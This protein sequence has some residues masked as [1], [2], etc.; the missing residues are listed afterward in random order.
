MA[1]ALPSAHKNTKPPSRHYLTALARKLRLKNHRNTS[2]HHNRAKDRLVLCGI[3]RTG[4]GQWFKLVEQ[5]LGPHCVRIDA[6]DGTVDHWLWPSEVKAAEA[7]QV[8][9][10]AEASPAGDLPPWLTTTL[11]GVAGVRSAVGGHAAVPAA[12]LFGR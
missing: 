2:K 8:E 1:Y 3:Q 6:A 9:A 7:R 4:E 11:A 12:F 5:A 10:E